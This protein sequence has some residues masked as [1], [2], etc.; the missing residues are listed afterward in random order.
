MG[1]LCFSNGFAMI[2]QCF[3][4]GF[5]MLLL[6]FSY[7]FA[8]LNLQGITSL[9]AIFAGALR[10]PETDFDKVLQA[11]GHVRV[12]FFSGALRAPE[13]L[14]LQG[15]IRRFAF[16]LPARP[17]RRKRIL[18]MSYKHLGTFVSDFLPVRSARRKC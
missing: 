12:R 18:T 14:N 8:M 6:C 11:F 5:A 2:L 17:V 13:M 9:F 4:Y 1:F 7:C 15:C 10:A 16:F 3:S